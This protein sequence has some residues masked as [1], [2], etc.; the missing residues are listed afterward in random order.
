MPEWAVR[1]LKRGRG[2]VDHHDVKRRLVVLAVAISAA[3]AIAAPAGA[4]SWHFETLDGDAAPGHLN[5]FVGDHSSTV[6]YNGAPHVFYYDL[7]N[8][9]LR[10]GFW[11]GAKWT[12]ET[13]DGASNG[14][15]GRIN[16]DVGTYTTAVLYNGVPHV[17]YYAFTGNDLRHAWWTGS[18][19]LFETIDGNSMLNGRING[20]VGWYA[21]AVVYNGAPHVFS[22]AFTG[23]DL[24]HA[25]W[26]G[27]QWLAETL[28]GDGVNGHL[29]GDAGDGAS[30]TTLVFDGAP[31]VWYQDTSGGNL[32]HAFWT[33]A[34]WAYETLDGASN[35]PDGRINSA[36]GGA[37]RAAVY[38][39]GPQVWYREDS[40]GHMRHAW[41]TGV[42]WSF[43][44]FDGYG[45]DA[46]GRVLANLTPGSATLVGGL[47]QVWYYRLE[48]GDLRHAWWTGV[49]W[50]FETLDGHQAGPQ[51][52][53]AADVG[54]RAS[55][56]VYVGQPH[57]FYED[58]TG[59]NLRHG[60]YA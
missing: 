19:W 24:R 58:A 48:T 7:T 45:P 10:H 43:E 8:G 34:A 51:G 60:W 33:G 26:T 30:I 12:L 3:V 28:D 50:S 53:V 22:H 46:A 16:G 2:R 44:N 49:N 13:L 39:T 17:F 5:A 6:L 29:P 23:Q 9:N 56:V 59:G 55:V 38:N 54:S 14:P 32:R 11:T 41:W 40:N 4:A 20:D 1:V 15:G 42:K 57:T 37:A 35:G 52:Q 47:P 27:S 25:W 21:Q 31:H 36:V 18:Q